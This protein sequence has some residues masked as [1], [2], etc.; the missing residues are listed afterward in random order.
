MT[1]ELLLFSLRGKLKRSQLRVGRVSGVLK[2][3]KR[4]KKRRKFRVTSWLNWEVALSHLKRTSSR[5]RKMKRM[6]R[7]Q[8]LGIVMN[9]SI[10]VPLHSR[11]PKK[12]IKT[13][14]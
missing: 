1:M 6:Q 5:M 7:R 8:G 12:E 9:N 11:M 2:E 10:E 13:M 14:S 3:Q 4:R